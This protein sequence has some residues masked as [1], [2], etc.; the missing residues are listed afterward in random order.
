MVL[1]STYMRSKKGRPPAPYRS[2]FEHEIA[3][4][5]KGT[6]AK[7]EP[8]TIAYKKSHTYKPDWVLPNGIIIEAK[9]RFTSVDRAKHLLVKQQNPT[10]DIRFIFK[11]NNRLYKGSE[12]RYS[13]W[14][15][16]NGYLYEFNK[17]PREW[18]REKKKKRK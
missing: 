5:L 1:R 17:V 14:C 2:W 16:K 6:R 12:T 10:L 9:G 7:Y 18:I 15:E 13:T 3:L 11:Y 8:I 4:D